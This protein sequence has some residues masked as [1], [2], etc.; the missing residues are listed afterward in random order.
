MPLYDWETS[1]GLRRSWPDLRAVL[2][3]QAMRTSGVTLKV[4]SDDEASMKHA[5]FRIG[6]VFLGR[7]GFR[8]RCTDVGSRTILA[9]RLDHQDPHWYEGPPYIVQEAV[10][11][12]AEL[13]TCHL[14]AADA[15]HASVREHKA[16][17]HP[18]YSPE[19]VQRMLLA[20][21]ARSY[22]H[23]GVLRFDRLRA[24]GEI[25]HPYAGRKAGSRWIIELYLPFLETFD[26]LPEGEFIALPR[27]VP[28]D[29]RARAE[30]RL[31]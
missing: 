5:D 25:L 16:S 9:I 27:A 20:R 29:V 21:G 3:T 31:D 28:A 7:A 23:L 10:F 6:T 26:S 15:L 14:H 17:L 19:V 30:R 18:G 13:P 1:G 4:L 11:D 22:P 12:E 24:D 8:W 2:L